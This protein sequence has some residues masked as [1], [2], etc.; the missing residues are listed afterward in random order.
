MRI[1]DTHAHLDHL[2]DLEG[3]LKRA[4]EAGVV[5]IVA[6]SM[7]LESCRK[8]LA[9]RGKFQAPRIYTGLGI[10]PSE[11]NPADVPEICRLIREHKEELTH[12]GEIGL[13]FWYKWV[14]KD[15]EKK[16]EQRRVFRALLEVAK[17]ADLP[18]VVHSRGC[19]REC[20]ETMQDVGIT[21]GEFHWYSGPVDVL[22]DILEA[23]YYV[24][25]TPSLAYSPQ[26]REA[27][28]AA[29]IERTLI[30]TDCPVFFRY[31]DSE[32][33]YTSEP[34]DVIQTLQAYA[35]LKNISP[36]QALEQLN[37]NARTFFGL[38]RFS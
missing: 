8:N 4:A 25:T 17:E 24:S 26:S 2:E 32:D 14:R 13:D 6:Q 34:K 19:W 12:V 22:E 35:A 21:K 23:G 16:D 31:P 3:A 9:L 36:E 27:I 29:P 20:L 30:E 18:A 28:A 5:G 33:G 38:E 10:H 7:D 37:Q 15:K 11:A 1:Y